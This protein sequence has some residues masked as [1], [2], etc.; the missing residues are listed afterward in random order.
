MNY[1]L[2]AALYFVFPSVFCCEGLDQPAV[3]Q[4]VLSTCSVDWIQINL[5]NIKLYQTT[6]VGV[7]HSVIL[8]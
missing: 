7:F 2:F 8:G 1:P 6:N 3:L 5:R 4:A